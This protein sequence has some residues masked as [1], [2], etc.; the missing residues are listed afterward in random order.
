MKKYYVL[1]FLFSENCKQVALIRKLNP[2]WQAGFL[3]GIGGKIELSDDSPFFAMIREFKE[4]AGIEIIT[5]K[6]F[7]KLTNAY[8]DVYCY[9]TFGDLTQLK[10]MEEEKVEIIELENLPNEEV[11]YNL[12]WLIPMALDMENI[13]GEINYR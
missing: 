10:S 1:G 5:W 13:H 9:Y 6:E 12:N 4:E 8:F 11:L 3:N 7:C 2:T